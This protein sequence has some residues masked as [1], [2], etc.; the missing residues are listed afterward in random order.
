[1]ATAEEAVVE[2]RKGMFDLVTLDLKLPGISGIELLKRMRQDGQVIPVLIVSAITNAIPVV[3]AMKN[4]A[5]DYLSKPFP[6]Q[7]LLKKVEDLLNKEEISF[8]K[9]ERRIEEK[10][11]QGKLDIAER[12]A[13][14]LFAINP[15]A[16]AHYVYALVM[17]KLGNSELAYRYLRAA[18]ALDPNHKRAIKE[19]QRYEKET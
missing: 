2:L 12:M 17:E 4:G 11:S 7:D 16:D 18:L 9:L 5:S 19:I 10:I 1:V 3:E 14:E 6:A 15:S 8:E 13:R